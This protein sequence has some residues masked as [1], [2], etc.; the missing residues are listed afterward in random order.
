MDL[1][2]AEDLYEIIFIF[3]ETAPLTDKFD[4]FGVGDKNLIMNS[5]SVLI[6]HL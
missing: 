6:I 4:Q 2:K 5:S 1:W 3:K